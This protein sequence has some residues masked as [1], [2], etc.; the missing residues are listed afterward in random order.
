MQHIFLSSIFWP[1]GEFRKDAI[2][3]IFASIFLNNI[4]AHYLAKHSLYIQLGRA[5]CCFQFDVSYILSTHADLRHRFRD[6]PSAFLSPQ[7]FPFRIVVSAVSRMSQI[8]INFRRSRLI[9]DRSRHERSKFLYQSAAIDT[10]H[11]VRC[12]PFENA[13]P[14]WKKRLI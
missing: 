11:P 10:L 5:T 7:S 1:V 6:F 13:Y 4:H 12:N 2:I 3:I 9:F 14:M 8:Q